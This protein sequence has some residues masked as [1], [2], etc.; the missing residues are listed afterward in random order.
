MAPNPTPTP[1]PVSQ[2]QPPS[3]D[4]TD[5]RTAAGQP[6]SV[7]PV[8]PQLALDDSTASREFG[9]Y[10][11]LGEIARGGVGVIYRARQKGLERVVALKVL[12]G[13]SWASP[14][15][16]KRFLQ[17]AQAAAKLQHPNIV[18][19]HDFGQRDGLYFFTM[20]FIEGQ[21]LADRL[22][23]GPLPTREALTIAR[24]VA[25][26]L[27]A[28][29]Q[30][31]VI[32]RDIKPANIL[33]DHEGR[34]KITDFGLAK[35]LNREEMHLT[36]TGQV[37]GTPRYM[38]PEQASGQTA[39]ADQRSDIF[40]LG[41][42]LYEM[43]TGQPAFDA[44]NVMDI[45][46]LVCEVEPDPPHKLNRK[47]HRDASAICLKAI[48][49]EPHRRYQTAE[50]MLRDIDR[51]LAGEPIEAKVVG[52][53]GRA[54]RTLRRSLRI[55]LLNLVFIGLLLY[56][57]HYYLQSRP[58]TFELHVDPPE[59]DVALDNVVWSPDQLGQPQTIPAGQHRLLVAHEPT[60]EP[61]QIE[62]TT[63]PAESRQ[64]RIT[65]QRRHGTLLVTTDP[66]DAAITIVGP[67]HTRIPLRGP[68][69]EQTLPT[70]LY[71]LL[72]HRENYL[73]RDLIVTIES[74][75]TNTYHVSLTGIRL[76]T[77][78]A[79]APVQSVPVVVDLDRDDI[80]EILIGDDAGNLRC[81][82]SRAGVTR[83]VQ[84]LDAAIQA[85]VAVSDVTGDGVPEI[86]A[87]TITGKLYCLAPHNG[88]PLWPK[89]FTA[90]GP[91]LS[92]ILL[93]DLNGDGVTDA[94]FGAG[95]GAI[96]AVSG[97]TG[98]G[99]WTNQ[100]RG[101]I[102]SALAWHQLGDQPLIL[103]GSSDKN[104]YALAP[105]TG[106]TL[107]QTDCGAPLL[108]PPRFEVLDGQPHI[109]LPT[110]RHPGDIRTAT[111]VSLTTRK[112]TGVSDQFPQQLDL[113]GDGQLHELLVTSDGTRCRQAGATNDLWRSE[114]R[115]VSPYVADINRDDIADLIFHNGP[116]ELLALSG[117]DGQLLGR[118][119]LD[120]ATGR[121]LALDDVDRDGVPDLIVGAAQNI[122]CFSWN[123]GRR[124]W[125]TRSDAYFDAPLVS[126]GERFY[127]KNRAGEITA[128]ETAQP[129]PVWKIQTSPQ[130][131]PYP[132]P[133]VGNGYLVDADAATRRVTAYRADTGQVVWQ[134][135][136]ATGGETIGAP[137]VHG[138]LAI[139]SDGVAGLYAFALTNGALRWSLTL[140]NVTTAATIHD[141]AVWICAAA[142]NTWALYCIEAATGKLRWRAPLPE[143]IPAPVV[144]T[145][146]GLVI[147]L[148]D[149]GLT[150][151][152][153][154]ATGAKRWEFTH[155]EKRTRT[156]NGVA[157]RGDD[158]LLVNA[159]G[160]VICLDAGT[161]QP[162]WRRAL[163]EPVFGR[164]VLADVNGDDVADLVI[165][166]MARR[167]YCVAGRGDR[168]LW[169]YEVGAPLRYCSPVLLH[170]R[171][172]N[173]L[174]IAVG[175]GPP[176]NA[177]YCLAADAP[178]ERARPWGG[179][180][181]N[182]LPP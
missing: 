25:D 113:T 32:H 149:N 5:T 19:I 47:V 35:E 74:Q 142:G 156:G 104:L 20:D 31:G 148:C 131:S 151:A 133:S 90:R 78:P 111:A 67:D 128:H 61:Q 145:P 9:N 147:G 110:P 153:D 172:R 26:A 178:R 159:S 94:V 39:V 93:R 103:A 150:Y 89:P 69:I 152:W 140:S 102:E 161:G 22:T 134:M 96:Y 30:Q 43:L 68:L 63:E 87:A 58:S 56:L 29:H 124:Q 21:S 45:L 75:R 23:R 123:G 138:D 166:T 77:V 33:L 121:G 173:A 72:V 34:V 53:V 15:Q 144:V 112:V 50:E 107:W 165:G 71:G 122:H 6:A 125:Q 119:K 3:T 137:S 108:L 57:W 175:T 81:L 18:P 116:D 127:A 132:G 84:S 129:R 70:G 139:V 52:A 180:W 155:G 55:I 36:V 181:R 136:M 4:P 54:L 168:I 14:D 91:I 95:N 76:W 83:W 143:L 12:Q 42:T 27:R 179:P 126:D 38:S 105:A 109:L 115:A 49:K 79:S 46:R 16:I 65:L 169:S 154:A 97:S 158:V 44:D 101:R 64:L 120:A 11:I 1:Q 176:E 85:P 118:I 2:P 100:T 141:D 164:A 160:D 114:Y 80:P 99:L 73:A 41:V 62:F 162:R 59:A 66:P 7:T 88:Q 82:G 60:H 86:F 170:D 48:E 8:I 171:R 182:L 37:M 167:V 17:E 157:L 177:L 117:H 130:P 40:S 10:E 13:G 28:A 98:T 92:A 174:S 106:Q 163:Q 24:Q 146:A 135:R 51:F